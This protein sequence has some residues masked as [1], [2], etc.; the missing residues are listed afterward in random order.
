VVRLTS[1]RPALNKGQHS[2]IITYFEKSSKQNKTKLK[3]LMVKMDKVYLSHED[4]FTL[5]I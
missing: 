1:S 5:P 4:A 2:H 3:K